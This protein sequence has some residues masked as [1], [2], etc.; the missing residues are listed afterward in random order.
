MSGLNYMNINC[1]K[2]KEMALGSFS[3]AHLA[4]VTVASTTVERLQVYELLGVTVN[5]ALKWDDH[6]A[7]IRSKAAKRLW[8]LKK[9]KRAAVLVDD[10]IQGGP[11]NG[12]F[13]EV[14]N[15]FI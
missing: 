10:L 13:L 2:T 4:P 1:K 15:S 5:S 3:K 8:F 6:V 12:P 14:H 7:A 11:R 9:L